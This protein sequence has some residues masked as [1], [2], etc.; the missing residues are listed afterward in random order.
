L[1]DDNYSWLTLWASSIS[2]CFAC[3][4]EIIPK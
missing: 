4:D 3:Y 1:F 2:I